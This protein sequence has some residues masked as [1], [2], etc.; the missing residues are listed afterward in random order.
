VR[1]KVAETPCVADAKIAKV[2]QVINGTKQKYVLEYDVRCP[3]DAAGQKK[4]SATGEK[5]ETEGSAAP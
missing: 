3:E 2:T 5:S 4:K 1:D